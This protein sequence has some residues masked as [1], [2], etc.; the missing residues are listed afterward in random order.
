MMSKR[1]IIR[2]QCKINFL[3]TQLIPDEDSVG[4]P[5]WD[6]QMEA[7]MEVPPEFS[8]PAFYLCEE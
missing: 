8:L 2:T 3:E 4:D 5:Y 1:R 7:S 6:Q